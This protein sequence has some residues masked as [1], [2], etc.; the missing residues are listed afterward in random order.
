MKRI[1]LLLGLLV[2]LGAATV[3]AQTHVSVS[4]GFGV[5]QPYVSGLVVV[6][7]PHFYRPPVVV[8]VPRPYPIRPLFV[9]RVFVTRYR[10]P[11]RHYRPY[12]RVYACG[13]HGCGY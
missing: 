4:F 1:A 2:A 5:P 9:E 6:E 11:H 3:A 10:H 7:R 13:Y 8:V 12:R